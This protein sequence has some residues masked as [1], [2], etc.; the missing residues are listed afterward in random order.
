[1]MNIISYNEA[2]KSAKGNIF[3]EGYYYTLAA[4]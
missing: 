1:M 4:I 2:S 3:N